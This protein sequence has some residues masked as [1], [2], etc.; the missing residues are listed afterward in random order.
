MFNN[1]SNESADTYKYIKSLD[2]YFIANPKE[3]FWQ[4][5]KRENFIPSRFARA[6]CNIYK[7][8]LTLNNLKHDEKYLLFMGLRNAESQNRS[9]YETEHQFDYYPSNWMCGLPIRKWDELS[10]W[11]YIFK[12]NISINKIYKYGYSRCGCI[13]CPFRNQHEDALAKYHFP[14]QVKRFITMQKNYF[15]SYQRWTNLNCTLDEFIKFAWKGCKVRSNPTE[16]VI[17]EYAD[18]KGVSIELA[19]NYFNQD[20]ECGNHVNDVAVGL[21]MKLFGRQINKFKCLKC[22]AKDLGKK[23]KELKQLAKEFKNQGCS[24]F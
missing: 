9:G 7:H 11:L 6:C 15:F 5:L 1:T 12:N 20:C 4:Y 10:I 22:L 2:N 8:Q 17:K 13:I 24:L 18:F 19:Q 3:G 23:Q 14:N 16:E 21:N